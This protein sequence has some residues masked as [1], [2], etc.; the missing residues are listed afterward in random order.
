MRINP[1]CEEC[2][3]EGHAVYGGFRSESDGC[4]TLPCQKCFP[5][6]SWEDLNDGDCDKDI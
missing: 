3:G 6:M 1:D 5:G 2:G 4:K